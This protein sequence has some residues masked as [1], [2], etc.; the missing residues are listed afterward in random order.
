[1]K[2]ILGG[3]RKAVLLIFF[4]I[5]VLLQGCTQGHVFGHALREKERSYGA[6]MPELCRRELKDCFGV[7]YVLSEGE[8]KESRFWDEK[9]NEELVTHWGRTGRGIYREN[10]GTIFFP[11]GGR[12]LYAEFL[13]RGYGPYDRIGRGQYYVY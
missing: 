9:N 12:L 2:G 5:S 3:R 13:E 4:L 11:F 10:R 1:M 8:E 7:E 6:D